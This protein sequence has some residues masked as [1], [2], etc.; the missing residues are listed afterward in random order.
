VRAFSILEVIAGNPS[1]IS[2]GD[3]SRSVGLHKSTAFRMVRTMAALG[4]VTQ[5][6]DRKLY[7][8][9]DRRPGAGIAR[10]RGDRP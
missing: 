2:L 7:R 9:G 1:G 4:Y 3:L 10:R 6:K 5:T 8:V